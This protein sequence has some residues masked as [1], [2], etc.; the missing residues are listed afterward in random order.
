[1][2]LCYDFEKWIFLSL[3]M[4]TISLIIGLVTLAYGQTIGE[5]TEQTREEAKKAVCEND[6][7]GTWNNQ[8]CQLNPDF[9][10]LQQELYS[11]LRVL[12]SKQEPVEAMINYCFQHVD[13]PNPIQDLID[14][15]FLPD[16]MTGIT[17]KDFKQMSDSNKIQIANITRE[18]NK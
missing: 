1:M 3:A 10:K 5:K 16:N 6:M 12:Q 4:V 13:R 17:C 2:S 7:H 11:S 8:T 15:G 18:L 9:M 14:K